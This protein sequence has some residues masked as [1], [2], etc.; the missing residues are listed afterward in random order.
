M[1]RSRLFR[2]VVYIVFIVVVGFNVAFIGYSIETSIFE[3]LML[4]A[5]YS[6]DA[7]CPRVTLD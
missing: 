3:A 1:F 4:V 7:S 5:V 2:I 6:N